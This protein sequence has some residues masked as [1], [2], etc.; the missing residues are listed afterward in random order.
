MEQTARYTE[1]RIRAIRTLMD[2]WAD[3]IRRELPRT[4]S[5]ELVEVVFRRP[6]SRIHFVEEAARV[7]R[8]TASKYL[9]AFHG[10]ASPGP[11]QHGGVLYQ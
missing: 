3:R 8:Q 6:H 7:T 2:E 4:Y 1:S 11:C 9:K 5:R 10:S